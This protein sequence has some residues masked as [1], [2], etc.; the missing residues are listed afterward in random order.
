[1]K[2][3]PAEDSFQPAIQGGEVA[4]GE[5]PA[6]LAGRAL[7]QFP[8]VGLGASAGGLT[9]FEAFLRHV[10][11]DPGMAFV[12]VQHMAP[13]HESHLAQ[14]LR[15]HTSL[16]IQV[17]EEE[18]TTVE[19]DHV[20]VIPPGRNMALFNGAL[21]LLEVTRTPG[22]RLA[23]DHFFRSLAQDQGERAIG[24]VLSGTGS[25]GALG[26]RA[27]KEAGGMVMS[28]APETADYDGMPQSAIATGLVDYVLPPAAMPE[29]IVSYVRHAASVREQ[30]RTF[31]PARSD[32]LQ[33]VLMLVRT[34]ASHDFSGY[35]ESVLQRR[36]SRRMALA[37]TTDGQEYVR[38]LQHNPEEVE[39]LFR[40][41]LI[42]VSSFFRDPAA[43]EILAREAVPQLLEHAA[44]APEIRIWVPGC[45]TGEEAYSVAILLVEQMKRQGVE[46]P[47]KIFATDLDAAALQIA[48]QGVYP[49]S[50]AADVSP[51]RLERFFSRSNDHYQVVSKLREMMVF[52]PHNVF[53]DPPFQQLDLVSCRNLLI[54]LGE[55]LQQ[56]VLTLFH[57]A[58]NPGGFLFTGTS[59]SLGKAAFLFHTID[60][61][62]RLYRRSGS[63]SRPPLSVEVFRQRQ[64]LDRASGAPVRQTMAELVRREA[65]RRYVPPLLVCTQTGQILYVQG[66]VEQYLALPEGEL[67]LDIG[68]LAREGLRIPL[69]SVI[70][71][72]LSEQKMVAY[73]SV[74]YGSGEER[75]RVRL[76]A[77]PLGE[78][79]KGEV[80]IVF[81]E[82]VVDED[83]QAAAVDGD[84]A[85]GQPISGLMQQESQAG[86][87]RTVEDLEAAY[88]ELQSYNEELQ[89]TNEELTTAKE[90]L[91]VINDELMEKNAAIEEKSQQLVKLND[92]LH[93]VLSAINFGMLFLGLDLRIQRFNDIAQHYVNVIRGDIG[94]PLADLTTNL[95]YDG[96]V[97]DAERVLG[98]LETLRIETETREGEAVL[99]RLEPARTAEN[100]INGVMM[101]FTTLSEGRETR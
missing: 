99:V 93:Q 76:V 38:Y 47:V 62:A 69:R 91:R 85:P 78:T 18:G 37:H 4:P 36:I 72:A 57:Y 90:E 73:R 25:D 30:V 96:L 79:R 95:V 44:V 43:F 45:A 56:Q 1:M 97:G 84:L 81:F 34:H 5:R 26:V 65:N 48:R 39:Q 52:A 60:R 35:K 64:D 46:H 7:A 33:R 98:T 67:A 82:P 94:R 16:P 86:L 10:P 101:I 100:A 14:L 2:P 19:P 20:Y 87:R 24:I 55:E 23:V 21:R 22:Q 75:R 77:Q 29:Q 32:W 11:A 54:Y 89:A 51:E 88:E 80:A 27:I 31:Y 8:V 68:R 49:A 58:L 12:L 28:Q 70:Q 17:V 3:E 92:E 9:A 15:S 42:S 53:A 59:E 71:Q 50:I 74:E 63:S 83:K 6:Q 61:Q 13:E 40:D 41:L 66:E